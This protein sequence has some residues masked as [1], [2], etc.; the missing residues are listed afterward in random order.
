MG[1]V[2][3]TDGSWRLVPAKAFPC[4]AALHQRAFA[5]QTALDTAIDMALGA[6]QV[7]AMTQRQAGRAAH[8]RAWREAD[9]AAAHARTYTGDCYN[10]ERLLTETAKCLQA[11]IR[12]ALASGILP[13]D[14]YRVTV[15]R[16]SRQWRTPTLMVWT[17][18]AATEGVR[19]TLE[20]MAQR[21]N[22][23]VGMARDGAERDHRHFD[24]CLEEPNVPQAARPRGDLTPEVWYEQCLAAREAQRRKDTGLSA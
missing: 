21:Y 9:E 6:E 19:K 18:Y 10:P 8:E 4:L 14:T 3:V 1:S 7:A 13:H 15:K 11:D 12:Q 16:A 22:K 20:G 2:E 17:W 5:S 23:V 24:L